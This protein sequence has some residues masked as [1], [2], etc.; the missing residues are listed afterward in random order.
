MWTYIFVTQC[1]FLFISFWFI[2]LFIY[3]TFTTIFVSSLLVSV[4]WL[5]VRVMHM[6]C[7]CV[8]WHMSY[9]VCFY[10]PCTLLSIV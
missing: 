1:S 3:F 7:D 6:A 9:H 4:H 2:Y 10:V 5:C 8:C